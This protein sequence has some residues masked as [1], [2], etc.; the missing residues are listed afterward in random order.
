M[1]NVT[2]Y[3]MSARAAAGREEH[4]VSLLPESRVE[5]AGR[6]AREKDRL[7]YRV[8]EGKNR[9]TVIKDLNA[10]STKSSPKYSG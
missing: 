4:L 6:Y 10:A 8:V 9:L 5:K 7:C 2:V 3:F 1:K